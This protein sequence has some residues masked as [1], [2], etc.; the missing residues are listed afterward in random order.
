[1]RNTVSCQGSLPYTEQ[2]PAGAG[3]PIGARRSRSTAA[4]ARSPESRPLPRSSR[5]RGRHAAAPRAGCARTTGHR[6]TNGGC[7]EMFKTRVSRDRSHDR[8]PGGGRL[9]GGSPGGGRRQGP[10]GGAADHASGADG[11]RFSARPSTC[12]RRSRS[13]SPRSARSGAPACESSASRP[14]RPSPAASRRR[15][16]DSIAAC[17]SGGDPTAVDSS[18][19]YRGKYQFD[20]GTWASVGGSGDP[21]AAPEAEQ[22]YRAA[23]LYSAARAP[24]PGRS[25][26]SEPGR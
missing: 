4:G 18:G 25:A 14:S 12:T 9:P 19:T 5:S 22:D 15:T 2:T 8:R 1:M 13:R 24:A 21:A 17:E 16:L 6:R 3:T 23:L 26:A 10:D 20:T 7:S 11:R